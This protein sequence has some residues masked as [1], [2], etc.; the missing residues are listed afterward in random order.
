MVQRT[1]G[2]GTFYSFCSFIGTLLFGTNKYTKIASNVLN[3]CLD[4]PSSKYGRWI[5]PIKSRIMVKRSQYSNII[6]RCLLI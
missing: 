1:I 5:S 2:N 3:F 4:I 6:S